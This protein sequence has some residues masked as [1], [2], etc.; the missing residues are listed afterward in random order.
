M[1]KIIKSWEKGST[2]DYDLNTRAMMAAF[3]CG[4]GAGDI[5]NFSSFLDIS[6]GKSW[7]I[8]F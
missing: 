3:Y 7:K 5:G 1:K 4:T 6:G 2:T 8:Y